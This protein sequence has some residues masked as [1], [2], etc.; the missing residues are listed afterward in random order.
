[1]LDAAFESVL[2][3]DDDPESG[4]DSPVDSCFAEESFAEESF[5]EES[6]EPSA[7]L[8]DRLDEVVRLSVL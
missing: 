7:V 4:F 6:V 3:V 2:D 1:M 5:E 8:A